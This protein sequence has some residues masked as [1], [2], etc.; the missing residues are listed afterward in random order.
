MFGAPSSK[1][2]CTVDDMTTPRK[3]LS[4]LFVMYSRVLFHSGSTTIRSN[5]TIGCD[6]ILIRQ[7]YSTGR[8]ASTNSSFISLLLFLSELLHENLS[9]EKNGL[10][11]SRNLLVHTPKTQVLILEY[12]LCFAP[13]VTLQYC[14][15]RR[16]PGPQTKLRKIVCTLE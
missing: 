11:F 15:A 6:I 14:D 1:L 2:Y 12:T 3:S 13:L 4:C 16:S 8:A 7:F 10:Y 9:P 5:V